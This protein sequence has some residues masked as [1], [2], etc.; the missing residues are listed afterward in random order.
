MRVRWPSG[1]APDSGVKGRGFDTY[2]GRVVSLSKDTF[3]PRKVLIIP[4]KRRFR[5]N[6]TEKLFTWMLT[7]PDPEMLLR[8]ALKA[9]GLNRAAEA[10][11]WGGESMRGGLNPPLIWEGPG[12]PP[13]FSLRSMYLRPHFKPF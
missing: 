8:G 13:E 3:T 6:M 11:S 12:P 5:P 9:K 4:R 1:R 7:G 2:L 10:A